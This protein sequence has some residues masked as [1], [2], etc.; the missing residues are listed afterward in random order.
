MPYILRRPER[1]GIGADDAQILTLEELRAD[2][3]RSRAEGGRF[4]VRLAPADAVESLADALPFLAVVAIEFPSAGEGRGYSAARLLRERLGF[5]GELRAVG[6]GVRQDQLFLMARCGF[7]AFE[8]A[9]GED[10]EVARRA[11]ARYDVAYQPGSALHELRRQ[12]FSRASSC[13][14]PERST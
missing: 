6:A 8:L 2:L 12:R 3:A 1:E 5:S 10:P 4:G 11:L 13:A 14:A 9:P 7:D